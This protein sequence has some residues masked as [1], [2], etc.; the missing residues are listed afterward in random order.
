VSGPGDAP[1][2]DRNQHLGTDAARAPGG[3]DELPEHD[4]GPILEQR[5]GLGGEVVERRADRRPFVIAV[6]WLIDQRARPTLTDQTKEFGRG[7][8]PR[9]PSPRSE[10]LM[11]HLETPAVGQR[12][13]EDAQQRI[14]QAGGKEVHTRRWRSG[15]RGQADGAVQDRRRV[16]HVGLAP[17]TQQGSD[18]QRGRVTLGQ[19]DLNAHRGRHQA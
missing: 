18:R 6:R 5:L 13:A 12:V 1:L 19:R 16:L 15:E 11:H 8:R 10:T 3:R 14:V 2:V 17:A 7:E 9:V 4:L